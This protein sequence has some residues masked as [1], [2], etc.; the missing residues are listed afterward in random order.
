MID[1]SEDNNGRINL[2]FQ[3]GEKKEKAQTD[4]VVGADG[5]RSIVR[6]HIIK[7]DNIPLQYTGFI[8]ILGICA[9]N[10]LIDT[11]SDLLDGKTIF[12]TV[13]G[14][15]RIYIMP[16][17]HDAIMWQMSFAMTEDEARSLSTK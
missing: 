6:K 11:K 16:Y 8:V 4:L 12:Q 17:S 7:E 14:H 3:V 10:D 9:L 15:E 2:I 13:N 5:I 1:L